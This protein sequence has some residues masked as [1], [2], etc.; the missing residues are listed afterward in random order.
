[1]SKLLF[2]D[3]AFNTSLQPNSEWQI[4][5]NETNTGLICEGSQSPMTTALATSPE[6][7]LHNRLF[8]LSQ[9]ASLTGGWNSHSH[10]L[11]GGQRGLTKLKI[12]SGQRPDISTITDLTSLESQCLITFDVAA[13]DA[14]SAANTGLYIDRAVNASSSAYNGFKAVLGRTMALTA[15][16]L[17][18]IATWFWFGICISAQDEA[19][20]RFGTTSISNMDSSIT[21]FPQLTGAIGRMNTM[22]PEGKPWDLEIADTK[23]V[24]GNLYKSYGFNF[25]IPAVVDIYE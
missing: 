25:Y 21:T 10:M 24:A 18:G 4:A 1:M 16:Q 23:I 6:T 19:S 2:G 7:V 12:Y 5:Y 15:A 17:G 20:D 22:N 9:T 3:A 8:L 14:N 13:Y 11:A